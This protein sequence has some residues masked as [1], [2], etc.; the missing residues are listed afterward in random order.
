[1]VDEGDF[2]PEVYGN[3]ISGD[4]DDSLEYEALILEPKDG[5][6]KLKEMVLREH[7]QFI[8][9]LSISTPSAL[10]RAIDI[11]IPNGIW[12]NTANVS[13][14]DERLAKHSLPEIID[15][16]RAC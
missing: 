15:M 14:G 16:N 11:L 1:M 2:D 13:R 6:Q 12:P 4:E 10:E 7:C 9:A 8:P 5:E 3:P